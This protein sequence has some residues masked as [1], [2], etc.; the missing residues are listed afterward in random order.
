MEIGCSAFIILVELNQ[1]K[2]LIIS[3]ELDVDES[4]PLKNKNENRTEISL[5]RSKQKVLR[6]F[7]DE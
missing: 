4:I 5:R 1:L 2:A 7:R 6:Y 3:V